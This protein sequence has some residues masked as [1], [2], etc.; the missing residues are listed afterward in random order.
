[1]PVTA[2]FNLRALTSGPTSR[3]FHCLMHP[4]FLDRI[5]GAAPEL[6]QTLHDAGGP[7]PYSISPVMGIRDRVGKGQSC[8]VRLGILSD[9]LEAAMSGSLEKGLWQ[10]PIALEEHRFQITDIQLG[11]QPDNPWTGAEQFQEMLLNAGVHGGR[12]G[13]SFVSPVAFK[14]GDMHYPLPEPALIFRNLARRW[15]RLTRLPVP[16]DF[17]FGR[18]SCSHFK[19]RTQSHALRK[20]GTIIGAVGTVHFHFHKR[21]Q[22]LAF[23]CQTLLR[24]AFYAGVGVKTGQGMGMCRSPGK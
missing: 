1:M 20:G 6:A 12:P 8:W 4:V 11:E 9:A 21:D 10:A 16:D 19:L 15:N 2:I 14:R 18:V 23:C 13:L 22:E 24:F 7:L 3:S 17:D 5:A